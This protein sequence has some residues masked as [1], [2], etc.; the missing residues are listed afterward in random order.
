MSD[1]KKYYYLK[2][3]ENFFDSEEIKMLESIE[4][5][6]L[7]SNILL[8]MFLRSLKSEG[9]LM[10][11]ENIPYNN[12]MLA[13]ITG[14]NIDVVDKAIKIFSDFGLIQI[15]DGGAI[16]IAD[17]QSFIGESSS[18]AD[19]KRLYR[20]KID[21]EIKSLGQMS[22]QMADK[23]PPEIEKDT[24][25]KKEIELKKPLCGKPHE[26]GIVF[27]HDAYCEWWVKVDPRRCV[28]E[29]CR[30][31]GIGYTLRAAINDLEKKLKMLNNQLQS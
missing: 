11:R 7:Y 20:L 8:K 9:R 1:N 22:R 6:Y 26:Q 27:F 24:E 14:H 25:L 10:F 2:L 31:C 13:A 30:Y 28:D 18:E 3:K 5:G 15:L 4:N 23:N 29:D 17:I 16:Y 19:R 21:G 12:K